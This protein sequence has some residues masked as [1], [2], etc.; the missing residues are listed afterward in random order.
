M[1]IHTKTRL[2]IAEQIKQYYLAY[3]SIE[4][5]AITGSTAIDQADAF[6][7]LEIALFW[8][9]PPALEWRNAVI[10]QLGGAATR[11]T[12]PEDP[13]HW[14][15]VD[16]ITV[17]QFRL[18]IVHN[19]KA[20]FQKRIKEVLEEYQ[21][22]IEKQKL[23][24]VIK[25]CQC[26]YGGEKLAPLKAQVAHYPD[27]LQVSLLNKYSKYPTLGSLLLPAVRKDYLAFY[28]RLNE[29]L[30]T[31]FYLLLILNKAYFAGTKNTL[32]RIQGLKIKPESLEKRWEQL[33]TMTDLVAVAKIM[34]NIVEEMFDLVKDVVNNDQI[35]Q[36][37]ERY[38]QVL[39]FHWEAE[40][41][42]EWP[43]YRDFEGLKDWVKRQ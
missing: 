34:M 37:F 16:N 6:S 36:H 21:P 43:R 30:K 14:M 11:Q 40:L 35:N 8:E 13:I 1:Q 20:L 41:L 22:I 32:Q 29:Y 3:P 28:S 2:A 38:Q 27:E 23:L 26:I 42:Q 17:H 39:R 31:T 12:L 15:A 9:K 19:T 4:A 33:Y 7:D 18:D 25:Y 24:F 5:I 10:Q